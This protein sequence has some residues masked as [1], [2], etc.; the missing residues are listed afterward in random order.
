MFATTPDADENCPLT[1]YDDRNR[2]YDPD[3]EM[4][5][6]LAFNI[7]FSEPDPAADK[8]PETEIQDELEAKLDDPETRVIAGHPGNYW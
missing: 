2:F 7:G 4:N 8:D 3:F 5:E 6:I 1:A